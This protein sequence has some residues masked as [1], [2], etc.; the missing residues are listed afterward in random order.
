[1]VV[2]HPKQPKLQSLF[3]LVRILWLWLMVGRSFTLQSITGLG[4]GF[5]RRLVSFIFVG[6]GL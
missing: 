3:K 5:E 4:F 2:N 1:M 6:F